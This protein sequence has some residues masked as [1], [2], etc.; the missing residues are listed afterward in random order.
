MLMVKEFNHSTRSIGGIWIYIYIYIY[1]ETMD[2]F[3]YRNIRKCF[4]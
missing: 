1:R 4:I 2:M 3:P